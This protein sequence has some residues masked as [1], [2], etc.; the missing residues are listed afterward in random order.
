MRTPV[1]APRA[2]DAIQIAIFCCEIRGYR[3]TKVAGKLI[4]VEVQYVTLLLPNNSDSCSSSM[5]KLGLTYYQC[6]LAS[7]V[8]NLNRHC[9]RCTVPFSRLSGA[10]VLRSYRSMLTSY[11]IGT[12]FQK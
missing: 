10:S 9:T 2:C 8:I 3:F 12:S 4:L 11:K 6:A 1:I 7:L 5:L